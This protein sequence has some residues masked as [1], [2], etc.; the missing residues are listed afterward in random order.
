MAKLV[1]EH[2]HGK[3]EQKGEYGAKGGAA[4][5]V[6]I[7]DKIHIRILSEALFP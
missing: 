3:N 1:K 7:R 2:D 4:P 5:E 6:Q